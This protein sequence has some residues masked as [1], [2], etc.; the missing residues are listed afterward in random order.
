MRLFLV[1]NREQPATVSEQ[2][3]QV[4]NVSLK[5]IFTLPAFQDSTSPSMPVSWLHLKLEECSNNDHVKNPWSW[6]PAV[7]LHALS[8]APSW[9]DPTRSMRIGVNGITSYT[10][11]VFCCPTSLLMTSAKEW[12]QSWEVPP[13]KSWKA[14]PCS[15]AGFCLFK[16][17]TKVCSRGHWGVQSTASAVKFKNRQKPS[18]QNS[19]MK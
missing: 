17:I 9:L 10:W 4:L 7:I 18:S 1:P 15:L 2:H 6:A 13:L 5:Y 16:V 19:I 3:L 8:L 12:L 11:S 14:K